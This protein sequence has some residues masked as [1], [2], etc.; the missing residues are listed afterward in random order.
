M[1]LYAYVGNDP[2]N[3]ADPSGM[4]SVTC[5]VRVPLEGEATA[6]C[7][8]TEDDDDDVTITVTVEREHRRRDGSTYTTTRTSRD[9]LPGWLD[10]IPGLR[11]SV[12]EG[13]VE[14]ATGLQFT[15]APPALP[16]AANQ[17]FQITPK[18]ERQMA[19]RGWS[20]QQI[21]EAMHS[22]R[23]V[24]AINQANGNPATRYVHPRTGQSVVVDNVTG[25]VIHV[26]GPGFRYGP[27]S[28]DVP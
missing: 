18:I 19:Q 16:G 26:G 23:R 25:E 14:S 11:D 12:V 7:T 9:W 5:T 27:Q 4:D 3:Q 22:G 13:S 10:W 1:N 6:T 24:R 28:G 20:R 2:L 21:R 17:R 8:T 15:D